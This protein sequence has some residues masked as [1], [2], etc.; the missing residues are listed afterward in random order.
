MKY[1]FFLRLLSLLLE[2]ERHQSAYLNEAALAVRAL[3]KHRDDIQNMSSFV[4]TQNEMLGIFGQEFTSANSS[5]YPSPFTT[6]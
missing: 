1:V 3:T 5:H 6:F 2:F 4:P